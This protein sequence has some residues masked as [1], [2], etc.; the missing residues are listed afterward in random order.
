[1]KGTSRDL[2]SFHSYMTSVTIE[3]LLSLSVKFAVLASKEGF[4]AAGQGQ[5][6]SQTSAIYYGLSQNYIYL[7]R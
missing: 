1:M 2:V 7:S 3:V 6:I 5:H 4:A